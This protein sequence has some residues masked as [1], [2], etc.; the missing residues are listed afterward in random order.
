MRSFSI[1]CL[2]GFVVFN[3]CHQNL[4]GVQAQ[5]KTNE[6]EA[7]RWQL[8][9]IPSLQEPSP[10]LA[11]EIFMLLDSGRVN[12]FAGC[13]TFF[14][15]YTFSKDTLVISPVGSTKKFCSSAMDIEDGLLKALTLTNRY[16][17]NNRQLTILRGDSL[18]AE[19]IQSPPPK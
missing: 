13:N 3:S 7:I 4:T 1:L 8:K 14:G 5:Q 18:L 12:G 10:E 6:L 19:F 16:R 17:I 11:K 2:V 9:S 15:S